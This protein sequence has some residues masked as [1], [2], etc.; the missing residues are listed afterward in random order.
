MTVKDKSK[1]RNPFP[2]LRP[3]KEEEAYLFFGR[4]NQVD[5][6]VDK[7][8]EKRF[9]SVIGSSGSGKSSLV[10]CGLLPALHGGLMAGAGSVWRTV[11]FRPGNNPIRS[12]A[13]GLVASDTFFNKDVTKDEELEEI[14]EATL[15]S[16]NLGLVELCEQA[17]LDPSENVLIVADQFEELFRFKGEGFALPDTRYLVDKD[18]LAFVKLLLEI[19]EHP[20]LPV[21]IVL[22]MRSDFLDDCTHYPGLAEAINEG[23]FLVP[24]LSRDERKEAITE[25]ILG[26]G[27]EI[28][29]LLV[30]RLINDCGED[31]DQLSIMQHAL[32]RTWDYWLSS[33][34]CSGPIELEHYEA[35][36]TMESALD[37]HAEQAYEK[38][39]E[40]GL[41][42]VCERVFKALVDKVSNPMGV[43]RPTEFRKLCRFAEA[44]AD[45]VTQVID[46]FRD[47]SRSFLMPESYKLLNDD[48]TIDISHE[49]LM[50]IWKRLGSWADEELGS[51]KTYRRLLESARLD[52]PD[53]DKPD[54]ARS[55]YQDPELQ[56]TLDWR[57]HR[58]ISQVWADFYS[59]EFQ[60]EEI[61]FT[62]AMAFLDKSKSVRDLKN[63]NHN[64][65]REWRI[66]RIVMG[67]I[68]LGLFLNAISTDNLIFGFS[69]LGL[70]EWIEETDGSING[71]DDLR[72]ASYSLNDEYIVTAG[73]NRLALLWNSEG[74]CIALRHSDR[75]VTGQFSADG[76]YLATASDDGTAKIWSLETLVG[77]AFTNCAAE[78]NRIADSGDAPNPCEGGSQNHPALIETLCHEDRVTHVEFMQYGSDYAI[79][80]SS[81]DGFID[82]W[83]LSNGQVRPEH[84]A[85]GPFER[86]NYVAF[87]AD[88]SRLVAAGID[89]ARVW[90]LSS[91]GE[92]RQPEILPQA[93][94]VSH[95]TTA[96]FSPVD[97]TRLLTTSWDSEAVLWDVP[98]QT[99]ALNVRSTSQITAAKT[100][101][102]DNR[103][104]FG[105]F[106][107]DNEAIHIVTTSDDKTAKVWTPDSEEPLLTLQHD[108]N[109]VFADFS[110]VNPNR[111]VTASD[112]QTARVWDI[113]GNLSRVG[114]A[115][116]LLRFVPQL[117]R[118]L[119]KLITHED[120]LSTAYFSHDGERVLTSSR[121]DTVK[122]TSANFTPLSSLFFLRLYSLVLH[123][124]LFFGVTLAGQTVYHRM[125]FDRLLEKAAAGRRQPSA[126]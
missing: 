11:S 69:N 106:S 96:V 64:F 25:P 73:E 124:G 43:R 68:A 86:Q 23:Q 8:Y 52:L 72:Y 38:I 2:G 111:V 77:S 37:I 90:E 12:L 33:T 24:R 114:I 1:L 109:V 49:S 61:G 58:N 101:K 29:P 123:F 65:R 46:V 47:P 22:T 3:Y 87:S 104:L 13:R 28:S 113:S 105:A 103:V 55:L 15:R 20:D 107:K 98:L 63:A 16:S 67:V 60:A 115:N 126:H 83:K 53:R 44:D 40:L 81:W 30:T 70:K 66:G 92:V 31:P 34:D 51:V 94:H 56:R 71:L 48:T 88:G 80:T 100:F 110:P 59:K 93:F 97:N 7:L 18:A 118:Y 26:E 76:N 4:D 5:S 36:G 119:V 91:T 42:H 117:D 74:E 35:I 14:V 95:L 50:R 62:D 85:M 79:A 122:Q 125:R 108:N 99:S 84:A 116:L 32:N 45:S 82:V 17:N 75:V 102:H 120:R 112:D 57:A 54:H 9:L 10:N 21:R 41:E 6:M 19:R 89:G 78:I 27:V 121:D 39:M